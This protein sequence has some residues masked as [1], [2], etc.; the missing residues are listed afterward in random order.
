LLGR[1]LFADLVERLD[2]LQ[3]EGMSAVV[4]AR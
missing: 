4:T 2:G 3:E 1:Q